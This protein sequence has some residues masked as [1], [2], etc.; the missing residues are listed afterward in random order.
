MCACSKSDIL[1]EQLIIL[2]V[3]KSLCLSLNSQLFLGFKL[4]KAIHRVER[5]GINPSMVSLHQSRHQEDGIIVAP[6]LNQGGPS[7][8]GLLVIAMVSFTDRHDLF[9]RPSR[10]R[11]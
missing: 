3:G 11:E 7:S 9:S 8:S 5:I 4:C 10:L 6:S 2:A 1:A